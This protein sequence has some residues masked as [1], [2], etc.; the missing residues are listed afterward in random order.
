MKKTLPENAILLPDNAKKVFTGHIF[1]VYQ[2]PQEMFDGSTKT[3]ELLKRPDTV[4]IIAIDN[5]ELV[6]VNDEQPGRTPRI[7]FPGGRVDEDICRAPARL[8][9]IY[10]NQFTIVNRNY[11]NRVWP[12]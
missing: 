5:G 6:L 8:L 11:L 1:D 3:F 2:W 9:V 7:H 10:Q 4:Q 12:F